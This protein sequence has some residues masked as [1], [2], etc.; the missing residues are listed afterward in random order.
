M[1]CTASRGPVARETLA[2]HGRPRFGDSRGDTGAR[3]PVQT[4]LLIADEE[5]SL[6]EPP[7]LAQRRA[8]TRQAKP[9]LPLP[10]RPP[11]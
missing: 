5:Q 2:K 9:A 10:G 1:D 3:K 4:H 8:A 7:A 11:L 6:C